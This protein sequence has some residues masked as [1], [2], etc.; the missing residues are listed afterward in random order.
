M[1]DKQLK[2]N[3]IKNYKEEPQPRL[4]VLQP[5]VGITMLEQVEYPQLIFAC[6]T[7]AVVKLLKRPIPNFISKDVEEASSQ[8]TRFEESYSTHHNPRSNPIRHGDYV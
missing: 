6:T 5:R 8:N 4:A 3:G 7:E 1:E 2:N